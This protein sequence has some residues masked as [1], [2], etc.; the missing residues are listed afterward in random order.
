MSKLRYVSELFQNLPQQ[1]KTLSRTPSF[2][3]IL[4]SLRG[5]VQRFSSSE[6]K[7]EYKTK[8][9]KSKIATSDSKNDRV[10]NTAIN[11]IIS[12]GI[13]SLES[14]SRIVNTNSQK[15]LFESSKNDG[16]SIRQLRI[17][18]QL[19]KVLDPIFE[20]LAAKDPSYSIRGEPIEFTDI[21]VSP[22]LRHARVFW[23]LPITMHGMPINILKVVTEKMEKFMDGRGGS[24]IRLLLAGKMKRSYPPRLR[25]VAMNN[26]LTHSD[27]A[28]RHNS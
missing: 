26:E 25:F 5:D 27:I 13:E 3:P 12:S 19:N 24:Q 10:A 28:L 1:S 22:D 23:T 9:R 6:K 7:T 2:S 4:T 14:T 15:P 17:A 20:N 21:E 11:A 8:Y 16:P 18:A